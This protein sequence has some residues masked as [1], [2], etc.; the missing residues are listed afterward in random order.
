MEA[1]ADLT[2]WGNRMKNTSFSMNSRS[3][4]SAHADAPQFPLATPESTPCGY[5]Q[6]HLDVAT[7]FAIAEHR[8]R[9]NA[10]ILDE[11]RPSVTQESSPEAKI[12]LFRSLFRER[13]DVFPKGE[14][15]VY[16]WLRQTRMPIRRG[17]SLLRAATSRLFPARC[18]RALN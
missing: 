8:A 6:Y 5:H 14:S 12:E 10:G 15:L 18:R 4:G 7:A 9:E 1:T 2:Q 3:R 17:L 13:T 11:T 16:E